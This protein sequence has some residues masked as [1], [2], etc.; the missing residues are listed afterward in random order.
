[1]LTRPRNAYL[2]SHIRRIVY[3]VA[4]VVRSGSCMMKISKLISKLLITYRIC[5][6]KMTK[7]M[8]DFYLYPLNALHLGQICAP[9]VVV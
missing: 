6:Q 8:A 7:I 2:K 4:N 1:M 3:S 5:V 9:D